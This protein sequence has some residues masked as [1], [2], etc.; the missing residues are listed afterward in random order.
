[1]RSAGLRIG[2][3]P[4]W[5]QFGDCFAQ[6]VVFHPSSSN[7]EIKKLMNTPTPTIIEGFKRAFLYFAQRARALSDGLSD[8][9]FW[10]K[11]YPY[12]NSMGHLVL[13]L[14]GNLSYY[15]GAQ[16]GGTGYIRDREREFTEQNPPSREETLR[17][18]DETVSVVIA[19]L[20][21]QTDADW[22]ADY[23]GV[24]ME[25]VNDRFSAF[26]LCAAHFHHHVGQMIY[27]AKELEKNK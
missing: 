12:G 4:F 14:T 24:G 23:S 21:R 9:Q 25:N 7:R 8:E 26:L 19:T 2:Q 11:P 5:R 27:L 20:E 13:H 15:L 18:L 16:I 3:P 10:T 22:S 6:T 1:V 17:R